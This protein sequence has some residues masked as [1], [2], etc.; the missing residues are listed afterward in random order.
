[1]ENIIAVD[2]MFIINQ[3]NGHTQGIL[4]CTRL[5]S[6]EKLVSKQIYDIMLNRRKHIPA[7]Q[8]TL[9]SKIVSLVNMEWSH[10][11]YLPRKITKDPYLRFFQYK[12][13]NNTLYLNQRLHTFGKATTR[14]CSFCDEVDET[15]QHIFSECQASLRLWDSIT[16]FFNPVLTFPS[17]SPQ[18]ALVGF[19]CKNNGN[20]LL[21]N[22]LLLLFK[23]YVYRSRINKHL[24]FENFLT[25]IKSIF[26][27]EIDSQLYIRSDEY[28]SNKWN[29]AG[30]LL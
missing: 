14:L 23:V 6:V 12:I 9:R 11:Y 7:A 29:V 22:H 8:T 17:L 19:H 24:I 26:K 13:L 15:P 21:I 3:G 16:V 28:Y 30:H 18:S 2:P 4:F 10:I 20:I 25:Y 5:V 27:L 1:M